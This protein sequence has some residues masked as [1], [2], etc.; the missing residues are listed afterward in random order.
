[1]IAL[2]DFRATLECSS[3]HTRLRTCLQQLLGQ[4]FL[5]M[6]LSYGDEVTLHFGQP[7]RYRSSKLAHLTKGSYVIGARASSWF[8]KTDEPPTVLMGTARPMS[9][10]A[11]NF[12][13]LTPE[14]VE[15]SN[16][17]RVGARIV[18][19]EA[20]QLET[21]ESTYGFGFSAALE[22]GASLLIVPPRAPKKRARGNDV[23][24]WE[25]FTPHDR[26]LTVGPGLRWSYLPSRAA[27]EQGA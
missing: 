26:Y 19:T 21:K 10:A 16:A 9:I 17:L 11:K 5:L 2:L 18:C 15:T 23:A 6:R 14:Q 22:D 27:D 8:L 4:P 25:V 7:G 13:R 24:D 1:M 12:K 3:D 20:I